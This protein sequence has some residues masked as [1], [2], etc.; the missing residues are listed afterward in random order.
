LMYAYRIARKLRVAIHRLSPP[1][2]GNLP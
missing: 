1:F 2:G